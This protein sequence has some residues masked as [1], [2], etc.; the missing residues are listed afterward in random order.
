MPK[1]TLKKIADDANRVLNTAPK[2]GKA[3]EA[4]ALIVALVQQVR[5]LKK[6]IAALE[7][8]R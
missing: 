2:T 3:Q 4:V 8:K 5:S 6:R 1:T 7:K